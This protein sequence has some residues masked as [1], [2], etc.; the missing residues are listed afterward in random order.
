MLA[1]SIQRV[2][3]R[4]RMRVRRELALNGISLPGFLREREGEQDTCALIWSAFGM[5]SAAMGCDD[6]LD[7]RKAQATAS[8]R[9]GARTVRA[10]KAVKNVGEIG[11]V[12]TCPCIT[13][14]HG[15]FFSLCPGTNSHRAARGRMVPGVVQQIEQHLCDAVAIGQYRECFRS[16]LVMHGDACLLALGSNH[17]QHLVNQRVQ[18]QWSQVKL[19]ATRL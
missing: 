6:S 7:D 8:R 1:A 3:P 19:N 18:V 16:D 13:Y 11:G 4:K 2:A 17:R 10:I 14:P 5:D 15:Q 12:D 9:A